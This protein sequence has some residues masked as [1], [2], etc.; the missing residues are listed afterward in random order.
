MKNR[1]LNSLLLLLAFPLAAAAADC[2]CPATAAVRTCLAS[3]GEGG[4]EL[5]ACGREYSRSGMVID[6]EELEIFQAGRSQALLRFDAIDNTFLYL[7]PDALK[8]V[9]VSQYPAGPDW[10]WI[11]VPVAEWR[12]KAGK[13]EA[14]P[15]PLFPA[16]SLTA[17]QIADFVKAYRKWLAEPR[18]RR[19]TGDKMVARL[20]TAAMAGNAEARRLF[21]TMP[22][23][24]GLD[25]AGGESHQYY[26]YHY[27][28]VHP[29][30]AKDAIP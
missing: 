23:D 27:S 22:K 19:P 1:A 2:V 26:W 5:V 7:E 28:L 9:L 8:V 17:V 14:T 10:S 24:A 25:G 16:P 18:D 21:A 4:R 30:E 20:A 11:E 6:A 12:F 15:R 29:A 3:R 13:P